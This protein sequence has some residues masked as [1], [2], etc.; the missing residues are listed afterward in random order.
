M[1]QKKSSTIDIIRAGKPP[2]IIDMT[3]ENGLEGDEMMDSRQ[4]SGDQLKESKEKSW[5]SMNKKCER[6]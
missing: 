3:E 4:E 1:K 6:G 2:R 5:N